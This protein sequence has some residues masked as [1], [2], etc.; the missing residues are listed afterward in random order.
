MWE[1]PT[2]AVEDNVTA[3]S[4]TVT[5]T[6]VQDTDE[7]KKLD[8][9]V[10]NASASAETNMAGGE[11]EMDLCDTP[12]PAPS[13]PDIRPPSPP[14]A[15]IISSLGNNSQPGNVIHYDSVIPPLPPL[16][17]PPPEPEEPPPLP[18]PISL[19]INE[20]LPPGVDPPDLL[21][22]LPAVPP[23]TAGVHPSVSVTTSTHLDY[24]SHHI[25]ASL[26]PAAPTASNLHPYAGHYPV[27]YAHNQVHAVS[28]FQFIIILYYLS[29]PWFTNVSITSFLNHHFIIFLPKTVPRT[30]APPPPPPP[31]EN[32]HDLSS[33]LDSFY[34]DL[35]MMEP[36]ST[37]SSTNVESNQSANPP[38]PA[39][40]PK[41]STTPPPLPPQPVSTINPSL[42]TEQV[43]PSLP[44]SDS[45]TTKLAPGLALKKKGVSSLV[46]KWQQVQEDMKNIDQN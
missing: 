34:S 40:P 33:E 9:E 14:P 12:P 31:K 10:A 13:P 41:E 43:A 24:M 7:D 26:V 30:A 38:L 18:P 19:D 25:A 35:A 42:P 44:S 36:K 22:P 39:A 20:P 45:N 15:P 32:R 8:E 27:T 21:P 46:A 28:F 11:E 29:L 3:E 5:T 37:D 16:P 17:P 4:A 2:A 23:P 1:Y 6:S